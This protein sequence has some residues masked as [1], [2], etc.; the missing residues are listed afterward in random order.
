MHVLFSFIIVPVVYVCITLNVLTLSLKEISRQDCVTRPLD[1]RMTRHSVKKITLVCWILVMVLASAAVTFDIIG[2]HPYCH[3]FD[4]YDLL[5][6]MRSNNSLI[7]CV[8]QACL[9]R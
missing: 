3:N 9:Y 1:Q 8:L 5:N 6:K 2:E 7:S 4:Q